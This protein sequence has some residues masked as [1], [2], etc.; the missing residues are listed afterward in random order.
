MQGKSHAEHNYQATRVSE[1]LCTPHHNS[2]SISQRSNSA[3]LHEDLAR[4]KKET[5]K[6]A[7]GEKIPNIGTNQVLQMAVVFFQHNTCVPISEPCRQLYGSMDTV[8]K[9]QRSLTRKAA[10]PHPPGEVFT[11]K[12]LCSRIPTLAHQVQHYKSLTRVPLILQSLPSKSL[13]PQ[14]A[15][16]H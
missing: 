15:G 7:E 4:Y 9:P 14:L 12:K 3:H 5:V 10:D 6:M 8:P 2:Q 1:E 16:E 13:Q 11:K